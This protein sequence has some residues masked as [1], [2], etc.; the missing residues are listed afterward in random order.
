M[1]SSLKINI[2][3]TKLAAEFKEFALEAEQELTKAVGG[4]AAMTHARVAEEAANKLK[5]SLK[6]FQDNLGFE[7]IS[8]GIW[9]VSIDQPAL[10]IEDGI[11]AGKD[12]KPDLLKNATAGANGSRHKVIPFDHGTPPSQR[13]DTANRIVQ[14]LKA[15][16]KDIN[17]Q[18]KSAGLEAVNLKKIEKNPD[19]SPRV[20]KLHEFD[21][22]SDKPTDNAKHPALKGVTIYQS[23]D[24]KTGNI[25]RDVMT[26]RT[27]SDTSDPASWIH[28]GYKGQKFLDDALVWAT[29]EWESKILPGLLEGLRK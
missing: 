23:K 16:L 24:A 28:P 27:V 10:W 19:G 14:E 21:L 29:N 12:M 5:S 11:E 9:V 26:F 8:P 20:G 13:N 2:D 6:Q 17:K 7:E 1:M 25:R 15:G 3:V 4:L 18:R 22:P